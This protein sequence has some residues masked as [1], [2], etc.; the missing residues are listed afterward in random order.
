MSIASQVTRLWE[1]ICP[2]MNKIIA[3]ISTAA[4]NFL[5]PIKTANHVLK[6]IAEGE[7]PGVTSPHRKPY[8]N[9]AFCP[10]LCTVE[11]SDY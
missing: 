11:L 8:S 2:S 6:Y 3:I 4:T 10:I 1:A 7:Q 9:Q 5:V